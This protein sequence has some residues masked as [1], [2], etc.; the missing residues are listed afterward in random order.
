MSDDTTCSLAVFQ[1]SNPSGHSPLMVALAGH[2]API[3][4]FAAECS[5]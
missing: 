1:S 3:L 4:G 2:A 5:F